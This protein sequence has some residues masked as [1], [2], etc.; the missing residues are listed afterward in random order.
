MVKRLLLFGTSRANRGLPTLPR[1]MTY[2]RDRA[3]TV[4]HV[5]W[6]MHPE[7]E[8]LADDAAVLPNATAETERIPQERIEKLFR[9]CDIVVLPYASFAP[10]SGTC[11]SHNELNRP[12]WISPS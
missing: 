2:L 6:V 9:D 3:D 10:H 5:A 8:R 11:S 7:R 1:A 12:S 4:P